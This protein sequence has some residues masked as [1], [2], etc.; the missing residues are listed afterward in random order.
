ML[1]KNPF[2]VWKLVKLEFKVQ[3]AKHARAMFLNLANVQA[4]LF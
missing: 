4:H 2:E 3:G 1:G